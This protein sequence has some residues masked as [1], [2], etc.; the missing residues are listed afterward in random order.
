MV[1]DLGWSLLE[2]FGTPSRNTRQEPEDD[3]NV[4]IAGSNVGRKAQSAYD[5][6][7]YFH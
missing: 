2:V 1:R 6:S 7:Q 4:W 5:E 3:P